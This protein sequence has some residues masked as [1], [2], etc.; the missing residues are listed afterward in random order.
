[1]NLWVF[2]VDCVATED[3]RGITVGPLPESARRLDTGRTIVDLPRT[4]LVWTKACGYYNTATIV[5]TDVVDSEGVACT[6]AQWTAIVAAVDA[7]T[8]MVTDRQESVRVAT[9]EL[10]SAVAADEAWALA[11]PPVD[12]GDWLQYLQDH[13][14]T[15]DEKIATL[16]DLVVLLL[17]ASTVDLD[18]IGAPGPADWSDD[19]ERDDGEAGDSYSTGAQYV[20]SDVPEIVG[21]QLTNVDAWYQASWI[22]QIETPATQADQML[23]AYGVDLAQDIGL[24]ICCGQSI[25]G[26]IVDAQSTGVRADWQVGT[27]N[28]WNGPDLVGTDGFS[29][30]TS[31]SH[32]IELRREDDVYTFLIDDTP[33]ASVTDPAPTSFNVAY[34]WQR[35]FFYAGTTLTVD[36][37]EGG[38][39]P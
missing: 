28:F 2:I 17:E 9:V 22:T 39:L 35:V 15:T 23:K 13:A 1:V 8:T 19:F 3:D 10:Q 11:A 37:L 33:Y 18:A 20:S 24:V 21:G 6:D 36:T 31:G 34:A 12:P 29:T 25:S 7:A 14:V 30:I 16:V 38:N 32:D 5:Q 4:G 27:V 26:D